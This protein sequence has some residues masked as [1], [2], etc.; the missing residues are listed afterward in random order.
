MKIEVSLYRRKT[1]EE[2]LESQ[3][4]TFREIAKIDL[5]FAPFVGMNIIHYAKTHKV[6]EVAYDW[7]TE[8]TMVFV[9]ID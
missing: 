3:N 2:L 7:D 8:M 1:I 4:G 6:T 5:P 9:E